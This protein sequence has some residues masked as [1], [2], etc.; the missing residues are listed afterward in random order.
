VAALASLRTLADVAQL[1][2]RTPEEVIGSRALADRML[3]REPV[4]ATVPQEATP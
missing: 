2:G 1:R 4:V 3:A